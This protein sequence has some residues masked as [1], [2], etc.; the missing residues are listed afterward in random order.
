MARPVVVVVSFRPRRGGW[1][2]TR[3]RVFNWCQPVRGAGR[4]SN[5]RYPSRPVG[6][7]A[8]LPATFIPAN[9]RRQYKIN[10]V[11]PAMVVGVQNE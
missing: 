4:A 11:T 7:Q 3:Q 10:V 5:G 8:R 1:W 2:K 9:A 6:A